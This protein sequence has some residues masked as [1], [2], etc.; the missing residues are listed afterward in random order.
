M[1][2]KRFR[3]PQAEHSKGA[4]TLG[5]PAIQHITSR[6]HEK[7][8][9]RDPVPSVIRTSSNPKSDKKGLRHEQYATGQ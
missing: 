5:V 8:D 1:T 4:P 6:P 2:Q 7:G 9:R 3:R